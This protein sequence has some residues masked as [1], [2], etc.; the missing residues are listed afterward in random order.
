M[1]QASNFRITSLPQ[2][3]ASAARQARRDQFG[4]SLSVLLDG[5]PHQCRSCLQLSREDEGVILMAYRPFAA[6]QPYA[7]VGPVFIHERDCTPYSLSSAYP[8]EF[9][10]RAVVLRA[11]NE[12]DQIVGAQAVGE[13]RVEEVI[14]R[15]FDN[16]ATTYLHARNLE[17]GCYMFRID[18]A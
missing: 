4:H 6:S 9:P 17:Y 2:E 15:L 10:R 5:Q 14:A 3:V 13:Q 7:E 16:P 11:Y 18:R 1:T 8:A 12:R